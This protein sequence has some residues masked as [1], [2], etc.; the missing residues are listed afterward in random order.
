LIF[1]SATPTGK[2]RIEKKKY[3][4]KREVMKVS[5]PWLTGFLVLASISMF[6]VFAIVFHIYYFR[7]FSRLRVGLLLMLHGTVLIEEIAYLPSVYIGHENLCKFMGWL[8]YYSGLVNVIGIFMISLYYL[9]YI[10]HEKYSVPIKKFILNYGYKT[11]FIFPLITL[12]PFSTHSYGEAHNLWCT[13]PADDKTANEWSY[14]IFYFWVILFL[15]VA[16]GQFLYSLYQLSHYDLALHQNLFHSCGVYLL[17]SLYAWIP[18]IL[19]RIFAYKIHGSI[20]EGFLVSTA[21]LYVSGLLY[22][23]AY[24]LELKYRKQYGD[25]DD[26]NTYSGLSI[27]ADS[28]REVLVDKTPGSSM[29]HRLSNEE[30]EQKAR[31]SL[32][33]SDRDSLGTSGK[34]SGGRSSDHSRQRTGTQESNSSSSQ[35][36]EKTKRTSR[37]G[38]V[39]GDSFVSDRSSLLNNDDLE[40]IVVL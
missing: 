38:A 1:E 31:N 23:V 4:V 17:I 25:D 21:Q 5:D 33:G 37:T 2:R 29:H 20:N 7:D 9:S 40:D 13:L 26:V 36:K 30:M 22:S 16:F 28:L 3:F 24:L 27:N 35:S 12:L 39:G 34:G 6:I 18:R 19:Y 10:N 14:G 32:I 8:H 15:L 11:A